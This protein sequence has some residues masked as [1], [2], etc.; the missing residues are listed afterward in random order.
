MEKLRPREECDPHKVTQQS[1]PKLASANSMSPPRTAKDLRTSPCPFW[2]PAL[3]LTVARKRAPRKVPGICARIWPPQAFKDPSP[4][5]SSFLSNFFNMVPAEAPRS[6]EMLREA[7]ST[8]SPSGF[9]T[10]AR[11]VALSTALWNAPARSVLCACARP[12]P[13]LSFC[14]GQPGRLRPGCVGK[15]GRGGLRTL[16][17]WAWLGTGGGALDLTLK[18]LHLGAPVRS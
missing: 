9:R 16:I 1:W 13:P 4:D 6:R 18:A 11:H 15:G 14:L 12:R 8:A 5:S 17:K 7:V 3:V 2:A 10:P